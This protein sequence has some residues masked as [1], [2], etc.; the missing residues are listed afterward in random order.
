M[1]LYKKKVAVYSLFC[2]F[3]LGGVLFSCTSLSKYSSAKTKNVIPEKFLNPYQEYDKSL[4]LASVGIGDTLSQAQQAALSSLSQQITVSVKAT[5]DTQESFVQ[6]IDGDGNSLLGDIQLKGKTSILSS[7]D[8]IGVQYGELF[9]DKNEL[10]YTIAYIN[11]VSVGNIY[12]NLIDENQ[13][14]IKRLLSESKRQRRLTKYVAIS[15]ALK[16]S[17]QNDEYVKFLDVLAPSM[18]AISRQATETTSIQLEQDLANAGSAV[19][20]YIEVSVAGKRGIRQ[21]R[22]TEK[23]LK[24][25]LTE[26]LTA[27]KF[28]V[29]NVSYVKSVDYIADVSLSLKD[30]V[31]GDYPTVEWKI[32][33]HITDKKKVLLARSN[34]GASKGKDIESAYRFADVDI[35]KQLRLFI[36]SYIE[37]QI[38]K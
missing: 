16:L 26:V 37:K 11:R 24:G 23:V 35:E 27:M 10:V 21:S 8:F 7:N 20:F 32:S 12:R 9:R 29:V 3:I 28:S 4:Y 5:Q 33:F 13:K 19:R 36:S 38:T 14:K 6:K 18:A 2:F 22:K 1:V 25:V 31:V 17:K 34:R 15:N 30:T